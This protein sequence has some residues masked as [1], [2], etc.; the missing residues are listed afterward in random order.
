M[1]QK[2]MPK[3]TWNTKTDIAI[4]IIWM[5]KWSLATYSLYTCSVCDLCIGVCRYLIC[6]ASWLPETQNLMHTDSKF[7]VSQSPSYKQNLQWFTWKRLVWFDTQYYLLVLCRTSQYISLH[8]C[9]ALIALRRQFRWH[10]EVFS[11][12]FLR[13]RPVFECALTCMWLHSC[14]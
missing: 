9:L 5:L 4:I 12:L 11:F 14:D 10:L 6:Q 13:I 7:L 2:R 1:G 8:V 3:L